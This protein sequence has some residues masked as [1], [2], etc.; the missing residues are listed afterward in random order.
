MITILV[1]ALLGSGGYF[2]FDKYKEEVRED[3]ILDGCLK[4]TKTAE[5][6]KQCQ[7]K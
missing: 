3:K 1:L 4:L 6:T 7:A 5:D 2:G